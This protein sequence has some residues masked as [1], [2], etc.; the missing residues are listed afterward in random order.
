MTLMVRLIQ[1]SAV[2]MLM[3]VFENNTII[4]LHQIS[5]DVEALV[6]LLIRT[7]TKRCCILFRNARA[8]SEDGQF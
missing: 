4:D 5:H 8:K 2:Q 1:F 7:F 3:P 6:Q